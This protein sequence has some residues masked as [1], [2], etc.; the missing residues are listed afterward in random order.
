MKK[1]KQSLLLLSTLFI[2]LA[3]RATPDF[4]L[5]QNPS[6]TPDTGSND[7]REVI[8]QEVQKRL[9]Q[10]SLSPTSPIAYVGTIISLEA[11]GNKL[12]IAT[13]RQGNKIASFSAQTKVVRILPSGESRIVKADNAAIG[14]N[15]ISMGPINSDS[16]MQAKRIIFYNQI[17]EKR[18][19]YF[20]NIIQINSKSLIVKPAKSDEKLEF[21]TS[22]TDVRKTDKAGK[23]T[24]IGLATLKVGDLVILAGSSDSEEVKTTDLIVRLSSPTPPASP[25]PS[26][27][28]SPKPKG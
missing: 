18:F 2:L 23:T 27:T 1:L 21:S 7:I 19:V 16:T 6:P 24:V 8:R 15:A 25:L 12:T 28:P 13:A 17:P 11:T 22:Q 26:P 5:A 14:D 20:G 3:V 10:S 4:V 9:S